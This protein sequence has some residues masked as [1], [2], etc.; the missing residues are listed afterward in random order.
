MLSTF[1]EHLIQTELDQAITAAVEGAGAA[2]GEYVVGPVLEAS[3]VG[4]HVVYIEPAARSDLDAQAL[5]RAVDA[6]LKALNDDYRA[7][8]K[9][10]VSMTA[11]E[12]RL[13]PPG[14]CAEWLR[15][16]GKL[17]GQHK[18]PR[19]VADPDRFDAVMAELDA[20]AAG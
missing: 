5:A 6:R 2:V 1:G 14:T 10:E 19:V 4:H 20:L 3:G 18:V 13:L 7:H 17:G 11:P 16:Q 8:R 12:V 9:G 15:R